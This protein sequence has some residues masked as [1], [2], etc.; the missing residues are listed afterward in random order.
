M[1]INLSTLDQ[2]LT[3]VKKYKSIIVGF[4]GGLDFTVL[5]YSVCLL[6]RKGLLRSNIKAIHVNHGLNDSCEEWESF[7]RR[8]CSAYNVDLQVKNLEDDQSRTMSPKEAI[9]N[10]SNFLVIGRPITMSANI[11]DS[12]QEIHDSIQ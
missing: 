11:K 4:S 12:L 1:K 7:C 3:S 8:I 10:G 6:A 5:L 9:D 2:A